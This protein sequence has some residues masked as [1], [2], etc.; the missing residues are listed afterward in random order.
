M[1]VSIWAAVA[2]EFTDSNGLKHIE[3]LGGTLLDQLDRLISVEPMKKLPRRIALPE[4]WPT[5]LGDKKPT[6]VRHLQA[7]QRRSLD[8][9][10]EKQEGG[11]KR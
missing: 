8:T 9:R 10:K 4:K 6:V 7:R 5:L 11:N 3:P 2:I 1:T